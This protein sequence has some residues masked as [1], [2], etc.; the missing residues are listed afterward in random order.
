MKFNALQTGN[1]WSTDGSQD[2]LNNSNWWPSWIGESNIYHFTV[3]GGSS[4]FGYINETYGNVLLWGFS[5]RLV[6]D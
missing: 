4:S 2:S 5:A 1:G 6:K 3:S